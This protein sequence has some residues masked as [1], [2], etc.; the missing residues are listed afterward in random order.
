MA[1]KSPRVTPVPGSARQPIAGAK[2]EGPVAGNEIID[3][4]I[5]LREGQKAKAEGVYREQSR[6]APCGITRWVPAPRALPKSSPAAAASARLR[7]R[8]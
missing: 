2:V 3:V 8:A 5:R 6:G 7:L 4:T 1:K